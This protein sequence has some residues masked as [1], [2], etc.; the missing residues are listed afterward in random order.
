MATPSDLI[1]TEMRDAMQNAESL[2]D[3]G[4][5]TG[6]SRALADAYL[7]LLAKHPELIPG[8]PP[9]GGAGTPGFAAYRNQRAYTWPPT[10]G[11]TLS[12]VDGA[13]TMNY[14]KERFGM[15][16]A[17]SYF[18][19]MMGLVWNLQNHREP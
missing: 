17:Y 13:P 11:I 2:L 14:S 10:G 9:E 18:E 12:V 19:F 4:D 7:A 3:E 15:S 8:P 16:E 1:D 5:Y 6:G